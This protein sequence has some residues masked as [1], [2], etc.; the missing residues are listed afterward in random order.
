V[1]VYTAQVV[2][3]LEFL[4]QNRIVHRDLKPANLLVD[5][6][7]RLKLIDFGLSYYGMVDRSVVSNEIVGTP[8]YIAPEIVWQEPHSFAADYWSL[9]CIIYELLTGTSPF[10]SNNIEQIFSQIVRVCYDKSLLEDF[11]PEVNELISL[12]LCQDQDKRIGAGSVDEIKRHPWFTGIDWD[13]LDSLPP[14][15]VPQLASE[16]DTRYFSKRYDFLEEDERDIVED[17]KASKLLK[18]RRRNSSSFSC[19]KDSSSSGLDQLRSD[20]G[21][22]NFPSVS[23]DSLHSV[24]LE[25]ARRLRKIRS[26]S[27]YGGD[28]ET[29]L[30]N[31]CD[32]N[33]LESRSYMG[34]DEVRPNK[35]ALGKAAKMF[36]TN[37]IAMING[38]C[39]N[40]ALSDDEGK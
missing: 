26:A 24:T 19:S 17:I 22:S 14:S 37:R 40:K 3:A 2:A 32:S 27:F 1:R 16:M 31:P 25:D 10:A 8:E 39:P 7:G 18:K 28:V 23:L 5:A 6:Q 21:I 29:S 38:H 35:P 13:D 9:G 4:R 20:D 12:L 15:F 36:L 11:S 30:H 33:L 34:P